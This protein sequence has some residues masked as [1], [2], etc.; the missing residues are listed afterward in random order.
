MAAQFIRKSL[1]LFLCASLAASSALAESPKRSKSARQ[2]PASFSLAGQVLQL[3]K[4][5]VADTG[6]SLDPNGGHCIEN[7]AQP[8]KLPASLATG[9]SLDPSGIHCT[10]STSH[11]QL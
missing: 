4:N 9:C 11:G 7:T 3:L 1:P 2:Q 10:T 8:P 6:C 5:L